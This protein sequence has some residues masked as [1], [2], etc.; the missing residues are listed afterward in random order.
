M[1][2][3]ASGTRGRVSLALLTEWRTRLL[4]SEVGGDGRRESTQG[5]VVEKIMGG[6]GEGERERECA[7]QRG[8]LPQMGESDRRVAGGEGDGVSSGGNEFRRGD[9][10]AIVE[11]RTEGF[12]LS[13][14]P[15]RRT[16]AVSVSRQGDV[17]NVRGLMDPGKPDR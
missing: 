14:N 15:V 11:F 12:A 4:P 2:Q 16:W 1:L 17:G 5:Q 13:G 10:G 7:S 8:G 6:G 3:R 9:S